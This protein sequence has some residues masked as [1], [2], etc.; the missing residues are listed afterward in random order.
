[1]ND[2]QQVTSPNSVSFKMAGP[3]DEYIQDMTAPKIERLR[4][5]I[6]FQSG[7]TATTAVVFAGIVIIPD[8]FA[9]P[10]TFNPYDVSYL[11]GHSGWMWYYTGMV[12]G[13][14]GN[15]LTGRNQLVDASPRRKMGEDDALWLIVHVEDA[16]GATAQNVN[17]TPSI[18]MLFSD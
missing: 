6:M 16:F 18:R 4:G 13:G 12:F 14:Q 7:G 9:I 10:A 15:D 17:V 5:N 8:Q 2:N 11:S 1:M 3:T